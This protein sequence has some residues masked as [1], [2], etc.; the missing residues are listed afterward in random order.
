MSVICYILFLLFC[1]FLSFSSIFLSFCFCLCCFL[2]TLSIYNFVFFLLFYFSFCSFLLFRLPPPFVASHAVLCISFTFIFSVFRL[3]PHLHFILALFLYSFH[4]YFFFSISFLCSHVSL[5]SPLPHLSSN[6]IF[7]CLLS[8]SLSPSTFAYAPNYISF[9]LPSIHAFVYCLP[10]YVSLLSPTAF[11]CS[12]H[13]YFRL[14][15][16]IYFCL[17]A[18]LPFV[19]PFLFPRPSSP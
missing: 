1:C 9:F 7:I 10:F 11:I 14:L 19:Y 4:L 6:H 3:P 12:L 13:S 17:C 8:F 16:P 2:F 5:C 18:L 15:P